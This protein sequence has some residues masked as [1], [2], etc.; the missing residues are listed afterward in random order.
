MGTGAPF[1]DALARVEGVEGWMTDG[2]ARRLWDRATALHSGTQLVEIGS[3]RGRSTIVLACAAPE[4]ARVVAID[5]H[6]GNDRGPQQVHGTDAE[7]ESDHQAFVANL[8]QAGVAERVRHVRRPSTDALDLVEGK[9]DLLYVDGAHR[10]RM[11]R[12]D[13]RLW[14][15]RIADGG[16]L[17]IHDAFASI[18]VTAA[19]VRCLFL[20]RRFRYVGRER[21]L[22]EYRRADLGPRARARNALRQAAELPWFGRNVALKIAIT[23]RLR[24][25]RRLLDAR[26]EGWPY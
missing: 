1:E 10:Y 23:A 17:L 15:D 22:A 25:L 6:A 11:V 21:S 19:Q 13:L 3:Y 7:G 4:G 20:N 18:G 24:P 8:A 16:T 5:P 26:A 14:T 9:I 2:Q 12:D